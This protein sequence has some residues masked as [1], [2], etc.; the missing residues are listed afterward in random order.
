MNFK[1]LYT[2]VRNDFK[3]VDQVLLAI[4][5]CSL[6]SVVVGFILFLIPDLHETGEF[7]MAIADSLAEWVGLALLLRNGSIM[8]SKYWKYII[9]CV[10]IIILSMVFRILHLP[11]A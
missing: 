3:I 1:D 11:G 4:I 6:V 5:M 10:F 9:G 2:F 7:T 8:Q